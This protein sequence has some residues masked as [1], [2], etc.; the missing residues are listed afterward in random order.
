MKG[1]RN[2]GPAIGGSEGGA[3]LTRGGNGGGRETAR[4]PEAGAAARTVEVGAAARGAGAGAAVMR[5]GGAGG[6]GLAITGA[7][8]TLTA[9]A[10]HLGPGCTFQLTPGA[11]AG[12][13]TGV[14]ELG[15]GPA[16]ASGVLS[17]ALGVSSSGGGVT[18]WASAPAGPIK[19]AALRKMLRLFI[20]HV[21]CADRR[22]GPAGRA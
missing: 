15:T 5:A 18:V 12:L 8:A 17:V 16:L 14:A 13:E 2:G 22:L 19:A 7:G 20:G 21:P 3:T 10:A 6:A 4:T 11:G 9:G 1:R